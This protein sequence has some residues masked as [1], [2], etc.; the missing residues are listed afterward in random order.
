MA[1]APAPVK[2]QPLH[3]FSMPTFLR[4][5]GA[6]ASHRQHRRPSPS[7][8]SPPPPLPPP[9]DCGPQSGPPGLGSRSGRA[10]GSCSAPA[11]S[12]VLDRLQKPTSGSRGERET[13]KFNI[14]GADHRSSGNNNNNKGSGDDNEEAE[15]EETVQRPWN[16]RPR[17]GTNNGLSRNGESR[18][19]F[20]VV[21]PSVQQGEKKENANQPPKSAR[22]RGFAEAASGERKEE[23]EEGKRRL[24]VS[25]SK[26]EI[27]EDIFAMT[28]SRPARRPRKR[29]R[30][31]QKQLDSVFPG[32]W[33]VGITA[34]AY[35]MLDSPAKK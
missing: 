15:A 9:D 18:E 1:T 4:W 2:S 17:R 33:L 14:A 8:D 30:S 11:S 35:R 21:N 13:F 25:L 22:L 24:W 5:G 34:D 10:L 3:N 19:A 23:A 6:T 32:L 12:P 20:P 26:D 31:V 27:E 29:P 28:G 16:L 7:G